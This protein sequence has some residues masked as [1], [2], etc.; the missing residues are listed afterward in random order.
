LVGVEFF[1][2]IEGG[3]DCRWMASYVDD[4]KIIFNANR[5]I[6]ERIKKYLP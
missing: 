3:S 6:E 4:K 1:L 5:V 2:G